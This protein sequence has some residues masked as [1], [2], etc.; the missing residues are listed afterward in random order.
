ML[1]EGAGLPITVGVSPGQQHETT[2]VEPLLDAVAIAGKPGRPRKRFCVVA[3]DK[4]FDTPRTR[5]QIQ[6]RGAQA[7]I[8]HKKRPDGS[9]PP[10]AAGFDKETYRRRNVVE[11]L[12]GKL[13][14][15]RRVATR[16][17]K[18][19]DS[20][21]AFVVLG[22]IRIWVKDLLSYTA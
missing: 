11:R 10:E 19:A 4:G 8:P 1:S 22:F 5:K 15:N 21:R 17:D 12:I 18:L 16:Y 13:K 9:Y 14:E 6:H 7:L 2:M 20:F 3:G